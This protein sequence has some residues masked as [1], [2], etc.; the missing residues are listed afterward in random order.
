MGLWKPLALHLE[1]GKVGLVTLSKQLKTKVISTWNVPIKVCATV[2]LGN[3][4]VSMV[5]VELI[6]DQLVAQMIVVVTEDAYP[7]LK[8]QELHQH[9]VE[10]LLK[11]HVDP[12]L[13]Q[14]NQHLM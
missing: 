1:H 12:I 13:F 2:G 8:W 6:A 9:E 5:T 14:L 4:N 3:A 7:L 11:L 10:I